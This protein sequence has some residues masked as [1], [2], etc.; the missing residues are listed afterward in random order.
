MN[1]WNDTFRIELNLSSGRTVQQFKGSL[2]GVIRSVLRAGYRGHGAAGFYS[3]DG[4]FL[5]EIGW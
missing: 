3:G 4:R 1:L 2:K 5:N